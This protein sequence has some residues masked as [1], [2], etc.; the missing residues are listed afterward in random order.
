[1]RTILSAA[2]TIV[3]LAAA[4]PA[5]A[6]DFPVKAP[7]MTAPVQFSWTGCH[8]GGHLGGAFSQDSVSDAFGNSASY[9]SSSFVGGG[10]IGCDYEFAPGWVAGV[11]ARA[12]WLDLKSSR[13]GTVINFATGATAPLQFT[14]RNDFL[15]SATGRLGYSVANRWLVFVRGG[16][17]WTRERNDEAFTIPGFGIAANLSSPTRTRVG[18]TVGSG[19]EWAFAPNWSTTLE[20]NYYDFGNHGVALFD[21]ANNVFVN[22]LSVKDTIHAVTAGVNYHF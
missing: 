20:Y 6:A 18:W 10:Q 3:A 12:S 9:S 11:E 8:I 1:M 22:G 14:T 17:A 13:A 21:A 5:F 16:P 15:A 4:T 19:V 2:A 7:S